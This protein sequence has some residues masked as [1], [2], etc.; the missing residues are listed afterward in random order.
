[1]TLY[2]YAIVDAPL[3]GALGK[4]IA[5]HPLTSVRI[6]KTYVVVE[7]LEVAKNEAEAPSMA[8]IVAHDRVV[9]RVARA[10]VRSMGGAGAVLPLRFASTATNRAA[11]RKLLAPISGEIAAALERVRG[12]VQFTLR[13]T[14]TPARPPKLPRNAGPGTRWLTARVNAQRVPEIDPLAEATRP[15][16]REA[17]I[18]RHGPPPLLASVYHLVARE[19]VRRWRLALGRSMGDLDVHITMTGPWPPYAFTELG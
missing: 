10:S 16:V 6:G 1:M 14:G 13:V 5:G 15:F 19:D 3:R 18:E 2:L 8:S 4:G 11:I 9:R 17:R 12:A 7:E